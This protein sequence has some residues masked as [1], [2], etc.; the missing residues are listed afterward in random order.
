MNFWFNTKVLDK[1]DERLG[2][3]ALKTVRER[4]CEILDMA[5]VDGKAGMAKSRIGSGS[6]GYML[7]TADN[8]KQLPRDINC[9]PDILRPTKSSSSDGRSTETGTYRD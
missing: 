1:K 9:P 2:I 4:V 8:V 3:D 7:P 5:D 6:T